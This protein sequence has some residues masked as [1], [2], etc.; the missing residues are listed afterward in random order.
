MHNEGIQDT[1]NI[2]KKLN[3]KLVYFLKISSKMDLRLKVS[4]I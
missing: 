4:A 2:N 3:L 1:K